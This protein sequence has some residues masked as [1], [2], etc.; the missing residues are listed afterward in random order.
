MFVSK[1]HLGGCD[2]TL[3]AHAE[4]RLAKLLASDS[5]KASEPEEKYDY[6]MIVIGGGSGGLACSKVTS[7]YHDLSS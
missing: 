5:L 1:V 4:G 2:N 6:D 3:N 7:F